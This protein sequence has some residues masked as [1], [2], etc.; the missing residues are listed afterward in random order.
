MKQSA[1]RYLKNPWAA[2]ERIYR[3]YPGPFAG[4]PE[5]FGARHF[6]RKNLQRADRVQVWKLLELQRHAMLM[7][8]SCG[9]FF[10]ELSG[11]ETVQVIQYAGRVVQLAQE[12]F[13]DP[14]EQRFLEKLA[15]A[16]SNLPEHRDGANIY[17]HIGQ[18]VH[19]GHAQVGR[20]LR[21]QLFIRTSSRR[22]A[23]DLLLRSG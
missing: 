7:Y 4:E 18:A 22:H 13:D 23:R 17:R 10:D 1:S 20:P 3:R 16:K 8:T 2:R 6:R 12:L 15:L 21:H 9:W 11:I 14:L 5:R 19:G